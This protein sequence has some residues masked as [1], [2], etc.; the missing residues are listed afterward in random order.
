MI[1]LLIDGDI[2]IRRC[3]DCFLQHQKLPVKDI[4]I[5][6]GLETVHR[7]TKLIILNMINKLN[8]NTLYEFYLS[9][10]EPLTVDEFN[11]ILYRYEN[12]K[13]NK[14]I[15]DTINEKR[16]ILQSLRKNG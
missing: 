16:E 3:N 14:Q 8:I 9:S 6:L 4:M 2:F 7:Y 10:R 11:N 13:Y 1:D 5:A 15:K 12:K